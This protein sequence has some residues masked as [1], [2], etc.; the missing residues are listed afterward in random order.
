M[1]T[2][3]FASAEYYKAHGL[4]EDP[5]QNGYFEDK[6]FITTVLQQRL[7]LVKHLL[8]FSQ[9]VIFIK[10]PD[11]AGKTCFVEHLLDKT[12]EKLMTYRV[13][14][15][16]DIN[17][18]MLVRQML[19]EQAESAEMGETIAALNVCLNYCQTEN[20]I[21]V[22]LID[23]ADKLAQSTLRFILHLV[24][25][26]KEDT[27]LRIVLVGRDSLLQSLN[28]ISEEIASMGLLHTVNIP[29]FDAPE[30]RAYM[31]HRLNSCGCPGDV[32][33][34]KE[35]GRI[36]KVSGGLPGNINFLARQGLSD[37]AEI[38]SPLPT[39]PKG[40]VAKA[41]SKSGK[42]NKLYIVC[43]AVLII[44]GVVSLVHDSRTS[45]KVS[46]PLQLSVN[47]QSDPDGLQT[48]AEQQTQELDRV[49]PDPLA[50]DEI[51]GFAED[52]KGGAS[53]KQTFLPASRVETKTFAVSTSLA[54]DTLL[55]E[56]NP[57]ITELTDR[58]SAGNELEFSVNG[59]RDHSWL[60]AQP[61][62]SYALQLI[63]ATQMPTITR[64][65]NDTRV[66]RKQ[67]AL[68]KTLQ[69]G[70][71]WYVLVYGN[72]ANREK[73]LNEVASLM[74]KIKG[75]KPWPKAMKDIQAVI[76]STK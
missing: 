2:P 38:D 72:Y 62:D 36:H 50:A 52:K 59:I 43:L 26:R 64:Y 67:L 4:H 24:E 73:A 51:P 10:G 6:Y 20:R 71:D 39:K 8:E 21:P 42:F 57:E 54:G 37:P 28:N 75:E 49:L 25:F 17:P 56:S 44:L 70:Q 69:S 29:T 61:A 27:F 11:A 40:S 18:D 22:L 74:T 9:Q 65:L 12:S 31:Q 34:D 3:L 15:S 45:E 55:A 46:V 19:Q 48:R 58:K 13:S 33:S 32:F 23:N 53:V 16:P 68:Y 7:D 30:T 35:I 60:L 14:A 76:K 1:S 47:P 5:F 41:D 63:G 66:D